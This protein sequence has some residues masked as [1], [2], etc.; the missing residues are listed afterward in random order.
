[1]CLSECVEECLVPAFA[2][3]SSTRQLTI[4]SSHPIRDITDFSTQ[5]RVPLPLFTRS[6]R[7]VMLNDVRVK[8]DL[9]LHGVIDCNKGWQGIV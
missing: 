1:M 6:C 2:E 8:R 9:Y 7:L 5:D 3:Q 4:G